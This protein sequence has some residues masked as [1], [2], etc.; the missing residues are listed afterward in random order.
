[1][2][3][4]TR[5]DDLQLARTLREAEAELNRARR[6]IARLRQDNERLR[7]LNVQAL[8]LDDRRCLRRTIEILDAIKEPV[9]GGTNGECFP[10]YDTARRVEDALAD[11]E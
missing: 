11:M 9:P 10:H 3:T 4:T 5:T 7:H 8:R 6:L 2:T 1:M